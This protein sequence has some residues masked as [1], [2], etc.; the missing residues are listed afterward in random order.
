MRTDTQ[1]QRTADSLKVT[2]VDARTSLR[3]PRRAEPAVLRPSRRRPLVLPAHPQRRSRRRDSSSHCA[4][5][6]GITDFVRGTS[7]LVSDLG[8]V[9]LGLREHL[10]PES[11]CWPWRGTV[12]RWCRVH[13]RA[14]AGVAGGAG[15]V[16]GN[17]GRLGKRLVAHRHLH[18]VEPYGVCCWRDLEATAHRDPRFDVDG[19]VV[20]VER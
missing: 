5:S 13:R 8:G 9:S 17:E 7:V 1:S 2:R 10:C 6:Y 14:S 4:W 11:W 15:A 16:S 19:R 3:A 18:H 12:C 20:D